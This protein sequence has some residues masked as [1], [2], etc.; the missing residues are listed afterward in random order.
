LPRSHPRRP[1]AS[2]SRERPAMPDLPHLYTTR[3]VADALHLNVQTVQAYVRAGKF[4]NTRTVGRKHLIPV[5]DVHAFL[6]PPTPT[7]AP[8]NPRPQPQQRKPRCTPHTP[9]RPTP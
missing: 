1:R 5:D 9:P 3:E 7:L 4:P 6:Y 2:P 8:R